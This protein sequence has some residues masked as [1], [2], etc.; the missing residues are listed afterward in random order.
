MSDALSK[1]VKWYEAQCDDDWEH[2][3]GVRIDTLDNPGWSIRIDLQ[4]SSLIG[5]RFPDVEIERTDCDWVRCRVVNCRFEGFGGPTNL[6][7]LISLF[8]NWA[9]CNSEG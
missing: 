4:K 6:P 7:E 1:L 3:Y 8:V 2:Q 5:R 9:D